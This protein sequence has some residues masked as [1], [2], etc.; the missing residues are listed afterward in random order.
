MGDHK[1][2]LSFTCFGEMN[3][4]ANPFGAP[5]LAVMSFFVVGST[6]IEGGWRNIVRRTPTNGLIGPLVI[7]YPHLSQNFYSRN[8]VEPLGGSWIKKGRKQG[9]SILAN[10]FDKS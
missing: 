4:I 5:L 8:M 10:P 2:Q 9:R 6:N 1:G 7:L 3:F